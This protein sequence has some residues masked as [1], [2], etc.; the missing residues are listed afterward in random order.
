MGVWPET[1]S[2]DERSRLNHVDGAEGR[3]IRSLLPTIYVRDEWG[4]YVIDRKAFESISDE[5]EEMMALHI[6]NNNGWNDGDKNFLRNAFTNLILPCNTL[7][8]APDS[9]DAGKQSTPAPW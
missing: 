1:L 8:S 2:E 5:D 3:V 4:N 7:Q 6:S 9:W